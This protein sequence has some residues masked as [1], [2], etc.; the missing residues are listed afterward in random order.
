MIPIV[1]GPTRPPDRTPLPHDHSGMQFSGRP[2][3]RSPPPGCSQPSPARSIPPP[4]A[5]SRGDQA[6]K[7]DIDGSWRCR[8]LPPGDGSSSL[9]WRGAIEA[10]LGEGSP[11]AIV[12]LNGART[13][14]ARSLRISTTPP[15]P[16]EQRLPP[17]SSSGTLPK[18]LDQPDLPL[19]RLVTGHASEL[20]PGIVLGP[21]A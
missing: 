2:D 11:W 1:L 10:R 18:L 6:K 5:V 17:E 12:S 3:A 7:R 4:A 15:L 9:R 8:A 19:H 20:G 14:V 16:L 13:G 21:T